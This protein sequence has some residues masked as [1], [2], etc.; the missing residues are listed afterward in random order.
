[1]IGPD[2]VNL[3]TTLYEHANRFVCEHGICDKKNSILWEDIEAIFVSAVKEYA[4]II[5]KYEFVDI[6]IRNKKEKAITLKL[7]SIGRVSTEKKESLF[8]AYGFIISKVL[9][10]QLQE[11]TEDIRRGE[12]VSFGSFD[13]T[14]NAIYRKKFFGGHD[15]VEIHR[16]VG[17]SIENG[18]FI[19][20]L[21]DGNGRSKRKKSGCV[22]EIPNIH[23][24]QTF[25]ASVAQEN[26]RHLSK[27]QK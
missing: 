8:D 24:A 10:R 20:E 3:G 21:I 1:M 11:L 17:C 26:L 19:I 5:P 25:I 4:I 23:L 14:T 18:E 16:I 6:V 13:I 7:Q 2:G 15:I 27:G 9:D 22:Y 12:R